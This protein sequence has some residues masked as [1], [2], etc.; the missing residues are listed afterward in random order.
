MGMRHKSESPVTKSPDKVPLLLLPMSL[1]IGG[2]ETHVVSL[3]KHLM[4]RGWE[5]HVASAGG[6]LV[7]ELEN[8]G[9]EHIHA[10]LDSRSPVNMLKAYRSID[11]FAHS[12]RI[13][14]IHA[15]ARIPAWIAEKICD[16]LGIP[17]AMTYH[18][19]FASGA[20]WRAFTRPGDATIA[21]S[22][23]IRDYTA[24]EFGFPTS[25]ITVIPNGIDL[26]AFREP[27]PMEKENAR[28]ALLLSGSTPTIVYA[29][30]LEDDLTEVART[31][32]DA[33]GLAR[34]RHP[35]LSLLVA[36]DGDG[37]PAVQE[38]AGRAN[39]EA[40]RDFARCAGYLQ[41]TFP[42]YA[43]SDL[44]IGM[45]RVALE[46]MACARPVVIAGPGGIFGP[47]EPDA[48]DELED[49]NYTSRSAPHPLTAER[50]ASEMEAILS[51]PAA[52]DS[53]GRFGRKIIAE[54]HSMELV[55]SQTEQVYEALLS[56]ISRKSQGT[57]R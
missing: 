48:L 36:G 33:C 6:K 23:D 54:R 53:M 41:D 10:P 51:D 22:E 2:A 49:R 52:Q 12:R 47:V 56:P 37:L 46:A 9:I 4:R 31:V 40:G 3:A 19:T 11:R 38:H 55:T 32:I 57:P 20:F 50:L 26:D 29:S 13:G 15:H 28:K 35:N 44:V 14:L 43:A 1:G 7:R 45:S 16:K 34:A 5:V 21:I 18:G 24:R 42:A 8:A 17:M 39:K 27:S 25:S 30:R